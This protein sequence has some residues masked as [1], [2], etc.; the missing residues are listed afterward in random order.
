[1]EDDEVFQT[2]LIV[3]TDWDF[4]NLVS[5]IILQATMCD[6]YLITLGTSC[7]MPKNCTMIIPTES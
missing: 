5:C 1:M 4:N 2:W 3:P 7:L 6:I